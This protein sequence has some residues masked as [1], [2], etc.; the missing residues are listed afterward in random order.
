MLESL[1]EYMNWK[2]LTD[3]QTNTYTIHEEI[4]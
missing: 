2:W 3:E 4:I 1:L